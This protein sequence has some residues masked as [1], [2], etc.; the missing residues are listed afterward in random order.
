MG[1][2]SAQP[3]LNLGLGIAGGLS[4]NSSSIPFPHVVMTVVVVR[5]V[6]H[7]RR[8]LS[9]LWLLPLPLVPVMAVAIAVI[10]ITV[11]VVVIVV[12]SIAV[13]LHCG[14][15]RPFVPWSLLLSQPVCC[16]RGCCCYLS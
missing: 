9:P 16:R 1:E 4:A 2:V 7:G 15:L 11:A 10:F 12:P 5:Q 6:R 14:H 13:R 8:C 3:S